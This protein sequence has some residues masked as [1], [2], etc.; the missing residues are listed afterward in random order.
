MSKDKETVDRLLGVF[1]KLKG[2]KGK[3]GKQRGLIIG[4]I[5]A[6]VAFLIIGLLSWRAFR[7]GKKL[8]KLMHE[9]AVQEELA[10]QAKANEKIAE[11]EA[12]RLEAVKKV[13]EIR[14]KIAGID[15]AMKEAESI[16]DQSKETIDEIKTWDDLDAHLRG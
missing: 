5:A 10:E 13:E 14:K 7:Q 3:G 16:R 4:G 12:R 15:E 2:E 6:A 11:S 9:K 8:A 1:R